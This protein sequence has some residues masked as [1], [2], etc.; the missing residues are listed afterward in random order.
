MTSTA[1]RRLRTG[2]V[3]VLLAVALCG[4]VGCGSSDSGGAPRATTTL[5]APALVP[6]VALTRFGAC[7]DA[8]VWAAN[9]DE[10]VVVTAY[11]DAADRSTTEPTTYV[12]DLPDERAEV[13][14]LRGRGLTRNLCTDALSM[15]SEPASTEVGIAGQVRIDVDAALPERYAGCGVTSVR[16]AF[17]GIESA[18]GTTF[19]PATAE[20]TGIGCYSG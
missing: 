6:P 8:F 15:E 4:G 17:T 10:T 11:L 2:P 18:D 20:T 13:Q 3:C 14:V 7:A 1:R 12:L 16:F 9:A 19:A 5:A